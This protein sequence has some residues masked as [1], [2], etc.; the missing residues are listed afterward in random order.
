MIRN[1][2]CRDDIFNSLAPIRDLSKPFI[3]SGGNSIF[4]SLTAGLKYP[5]GYSMTFLATY[6]WNG[7][8]L[9]KDLVCFEGLVN[10]IV[11]FLDGFRACS[12]KG[13][14]GFRR[15][16]GNDTAGFN[17]A[18]SRDSRTLR[19]GYTPFDHFLSC[20]LE[21]RLYVCHIYIFSP[22]LLAF[23]GRLLVLLRCF[24]RWSHDYTRICQNGATV[25]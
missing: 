5:I 4:P 11:R 6:G 15:F 7:R 24:L 25:L 8:A 18:P 19:I 17:L 22:R 12:V 10:F 20:F 9:S 2:V 13:E 1:T 16:F 14:E 23:A 21:A 3:V